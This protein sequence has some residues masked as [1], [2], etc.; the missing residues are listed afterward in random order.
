MNNKN[1]KLLMV[2]VALPLVAA[3]CNRGGSVSDET[4]SVTIAEQTLSVQVA[5]T[6]E[7]REQGL[8][9]RESLGENEGMLFKFPVA[10]KYG[11]WMKDMKFPLDL[12]WIKDGKV[13][14]V[15]LNAKPEPG[16]QDSAL[17]RY[18]SQQEIDSVLEV[19]AGWAV[20]NKIR[21]GD[22]VDVTE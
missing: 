2:L 12:I 11:F 13:A 21:V 14:E 6:P 17:Y 16:V 8:S 15:T 5:D 10:G 18:V 19:N 7:L 4:A 3:G 20:Q 1:Y 9:G 22:S